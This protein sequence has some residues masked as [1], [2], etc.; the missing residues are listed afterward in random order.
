LLGC[1][2]VALVFFILAPE[3]AADSLLPRLRKAIYAT[4]VL[5]PGGSAWHTDEQIQ[6]TTSETTRLTAEI[7]QVANDAQVEG[8]SSLVNHQAIVDA[9]GTLRGIANRFSVI[10]S[11]RS[12][13]RS[14][15]LNFAT[16]SAR[17]EAFNK[18]RRQLETWLAF[19]SGPNSINASAAREIAQAHPP[20]DLANP[21]DE[22]SSRLEE[23]SYEQMQSWTFPQRRMML[24]ELESMRRLEVLFSDLNRYLAQIPGPSRPAAA[25]SNDKLVG[26][27]EIGA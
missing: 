13:M 22:F 24:A 5:A 2:V 20:Q 18:A 8:R 21:I 4:L 16:E 6:Q 10:A 9:A 3:Y 26:K 11:E 19:F 7:L 25:L 15:Q 27:G 17:E 14:S 12:L 23:N 1:F